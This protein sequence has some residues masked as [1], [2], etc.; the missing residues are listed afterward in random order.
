MTRRDV[1]RAAGGG[2]IGPDGKGRQTGSQRWVLEF[3]GGAERRG[4]T[5]VG[6]RV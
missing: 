1:C 5:E 3:R 4:R 2:A 6:G